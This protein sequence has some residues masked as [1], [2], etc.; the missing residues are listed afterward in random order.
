MP[1]VYQ[2]SVDRPLL[3]EVETARAAGIALR[4]K[5]VVVLRPGKIIA[6]FLTPELNVTVR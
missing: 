2:L 6:G 5:P 3:A 4:P 1:G